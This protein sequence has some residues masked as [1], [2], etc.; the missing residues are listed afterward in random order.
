MFDKIS[1][2]LIFDFNTCNLVVP[3]L[4][5]QLLVKFQAKIAGKID[6]IELNDLWS[7]W[8]KN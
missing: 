8:L 3:I 7:K 5:N 4:I 6:K 2:F 1:K